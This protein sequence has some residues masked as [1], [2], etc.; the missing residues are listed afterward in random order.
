MREGRKE[1]DCDAAGCSR[2]AQLEVMG[3]PNREVVRV[4]MPPLAREPSGRAMPLLALPFLMGVAKVPPPFIP[5]FILPFI[6][7]FIPPFIL[8]F[9]PLLIAPF[10]PPF[11]PPLI[12]LL[13][14]PPIA[15]LTEEALMD[16]AGMKEVGLDRMDT[17]SRPKNEDR[18]SL[19]DT[20]ECIDTSSR[21]K[22]VAGRDSELDTEGIVYIELRCEGA[23]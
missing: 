8:P 17:S 23:L 14:A 5:P 21:A 9:I 16:D 2:G 12:P 1:S 4:L 15:P 18:G 3:P 22:K 7:P 11:I 20:A 10:I 19:E 6:L 13:I